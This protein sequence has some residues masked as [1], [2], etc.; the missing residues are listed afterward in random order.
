MEPLIM[1]TLQLIN[2]EIDITNSK[3]LFNTIITEGN[4]AEHFETHNSKWTVS[5]GWITGRNPEESAGMAIMKQDFP[6]NILLEF[7]CRTV[8]PSTHDINFMWNGEWSDDL[9]SCGNAY[10]GSICGWYSGRA[11]I[12]K[13]PEN[14]LSATI[15]NDGFVPGMTYRVHAGSVDGDCFI[16]IDGKLAVELTDPDPID[17]RLFTK[18]AFTA[19]SSC[20]QVRNIIIRQVKW[21]PLK[22]SYKNEFKC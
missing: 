10:I 21:K 12:E 15:P 18:V 9:N 22:L 17:N 8:P 20:I 6:G 19:W 4:F 16:S 7:D 14:K 13:S 1:H 11:G 5:D 3:I 2:K